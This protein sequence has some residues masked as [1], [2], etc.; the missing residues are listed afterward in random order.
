LKGNLSTEDA[1]PENRDLIERGKHVLPLK[2]MAMPGD[3]TTPAP[4]PQRNQLWKDL[5]G[6]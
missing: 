3:R 5:I 6:S 4:K 2:W 1:R